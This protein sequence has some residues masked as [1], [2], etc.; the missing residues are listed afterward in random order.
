MARRAAL[1]ILE[2]YCHGPPPFV[3]TTSKPS[4]ARESEEAAC[5]RHS[6]QRSAW[7]QRL[8]PTL[9]M[10][11]VR[12]HAIMQ[13]RVE[14]AALG[15]SRRG[16]PL[17]VLEGAKGAHEQPEVLHSLDQ[18]RGACLETPKAHAGA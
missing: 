11:E 18:G 17:H 13:R 12:E 5:V 9:S 6:C 7:L 1:L 15:A 10:V 2:P 8:L 16:E 14:P 3:S 4:C